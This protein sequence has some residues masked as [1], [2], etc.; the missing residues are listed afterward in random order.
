MTPDWGSLEQSRTKTTPSS[1]SF[2]A[3]HWT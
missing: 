3:H 2:P 1:G